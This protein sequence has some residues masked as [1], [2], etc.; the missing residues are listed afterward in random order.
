VFQD[1]SLYTVLIQQQ[2]SI[3]NRCRNLCSRLP[4][5]IAAAPWCHCCELK[6][7]LHPTR[8]HYDTVA[9]SRRKPR[10]KVQSCVGYRVS[11]GT[12]GVVLCKS[13]DFEIRTLS[14]CIILEEKKKEVQAGKRI[15]ILEFL[16]FLG[17][18][19]ELCWLTNTKRP[20]LHL[21]E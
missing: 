5:C 3:H 6:M 12:K 2:V 7:N 17:S 15:Y 9:Y 20:N 8:Q 4:L 19:C 14:V 10:G 18:T 21:A 13:R 11:F 16:R 1:E